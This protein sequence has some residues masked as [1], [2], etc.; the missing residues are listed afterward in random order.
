MNLIFDDNTSM[1]FSAQVCNQLAT[2]A[3]CKSTKFSKQIQDQIELDTGIVSPTAMLM[4]GAWIEWHLIH[5]ASFPL[6]E[7]DADRHTT[8]S[9]FLSWQQRV[10][11]WATGKPQHVIDFEKS[12]FDACKQIVSADPE[13]NR[14][15]LGDILCVVN[16]L[17]CEPLSIT[18]ANY[19]EKHVDQ[20]EAIVDL[21]FWVTHIVKGACRLFFSIDLL[22]NDMYDDATRKWCNIFVATPTSYF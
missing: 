9:N 13:Q 10:R 22:S 1:H 2:L 17:E 21:L 19:I 16:Y 18:I 4:I 5:D 11:A 15:L 8:S 20:N 14:G 3:S 7:S 12:W 6:L